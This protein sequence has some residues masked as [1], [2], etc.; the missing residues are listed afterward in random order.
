M[1]PSCRD[2]HM[3][4]YMYIV[5]V[6]YSAVW[7]C[8]IYMYVHVCGLLDIRVTSNFMLCIPAVLC[9]ILGR[10]HYIIRT[11]MYIV[12]VM[13]IHVRPISITYHD[14][15]VQW[16][17]SHVCNVFIYSNLY[18]GPDPNELVGR[19]TVLPLHV[20]VHVHMY[21]HTHTTLGVNGYYVHVPSI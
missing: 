18:T 13:Y 5:H 2:I 21:V 20:H 12:H 6:C 11:Y 9:F 1:S 15:H 3:Y 16:S 8:I 10:H 17:L 7:T 19:I 14:L 4:M